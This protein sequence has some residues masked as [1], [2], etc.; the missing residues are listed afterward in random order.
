[1]LKSST[2]TSPKVFAALPCFN[3]ERFIREVVLKARKYVDQVIVIDDGSRDGTF[4]AAKAA[5]ALVIKH[6]VNQGTGEATKSCFKEARRKGAH[7]LVTLDGDGQHDPDGIPQIL[8]PILEGKADVVI[9]CRL[10]TDHSS[11]PKYRR[12]GINVITWLFNLGSKLR[13]SDAQSCFRAYGERALYSLNITERGFG[14]S[15]ELLIQARQRGF[16]ITEVPISCI[17][18]SASHSA[19]PVIHGLGVAF[20]VVKLRLESLF[21]RLIGSSR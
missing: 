3:T 21:H 16:T 11:M 2:K 17:Y 1:M 6:E 10:L 5:G 8:A 12:F 20:A 15:V 13:V 7:V 14:F 4:E 9:G 19:N 18:H